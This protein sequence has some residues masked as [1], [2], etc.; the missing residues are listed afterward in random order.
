MARGSRELKIPPRAHEAV[1]A[2]HVLGPCYVKYTNEPTGLA[3]MVPS[4]WALPVVLVPPLLV[5]HTSSVAS[6][7]R[8]TLEPGDGSQLLPNSLTSSLQ[9]YEGGG[10]TLYPWHVSVCNLSTFPDVS[11]LTRR[12]RLP[13]AYVPFG[14]RDQLVPWE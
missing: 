8:F 13:C 12:G 2:T 4:G 9:V 10:L 5:V 1:A 11:L 3:R 7:S 14:R 6:P